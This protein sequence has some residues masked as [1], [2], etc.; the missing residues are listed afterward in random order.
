MK[1]LIFLA[2]LALLTSACAIESLFH[3]EQA[4]F[5]EVAELPPLP[6]GPPAKPNCVTAM[7]SVSLREMITE[8]RYVVIVTVSDVGGSESAGGVPY[9][10][11]RTQLDEAL[12]GRVDATLDFALINCVG[13]RYDF[14]PGKQYLIFAERRAFGGTVRVIAPMGYEHGVFKLEDG[15][16][17]GLR[18]VFSIAEIRE[19]LSRQSAACPQAFLLRAFSPA[20]EPASCEGERSVELCL[21]CRAVS[22]EGLPPLAVIPD[23]DAHFIVHFDPNL[24]TPAGGRN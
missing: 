4:E 13:T 8:A 14:E 19:R 22:R 20:S 7:E 6:P 21:E 23:V 15:M 9:F 1:R 5:R 3:G 2:A 16:A 10:R 24:T 12:R 18:G 11:V 17:I